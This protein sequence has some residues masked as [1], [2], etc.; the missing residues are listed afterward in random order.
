MARVMGSAFLGSDSRQLF[1]QFL[2]VAFVGRPFAAEPCGV[3]SRGSAKS[4]NT[5]ATAA[6]VSPSSIT[7]GMSAKSAIPTTSMP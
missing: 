7:S 4:I 6:N 3:D 2:I 1:E 5:Q